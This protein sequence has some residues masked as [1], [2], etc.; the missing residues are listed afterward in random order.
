ML[1]SFGSL[2]QEECINVAWKKMGYDLTQARTLGWLAHASC[3]DVFSDPDQYIQNRDMAVSFLGTFKG[4]D[5]LDALDFLD[6][7]GKADQKIFTEMV[8]LVLTDLIILRKNLGDIVNADIR[9]N[10]KD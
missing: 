6:R 7:I 2:S 1:F 10:K 3:S 8:L 9:T 5:P 4:E